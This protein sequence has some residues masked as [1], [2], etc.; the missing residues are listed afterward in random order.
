MTS[1]M[2]ENCAAG[3]SSQRSTARS[4]IPRG[5]RDVGEDDLQSVEEDR[6]SGCSSRCSAI[7]C[8]H[9]G[10]GGGGGGRVDLLCACDERNLSGSSPSG[11]SRCD[12]TPSGSST[13]QLKSHSRACRSLPRG[14]IALRRRGAETSER[15]G[16]GRRSVIPAD[17]KRRQH[18]EMDRYE[19]RPTTSSRSAST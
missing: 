9:G 18:G 3:P 1:W 19:L 13:L 2:R 17:A 5:T 7:G 10:R 11:R 8:I 4:R 14:R 12:S 15:R 16:A 6:T